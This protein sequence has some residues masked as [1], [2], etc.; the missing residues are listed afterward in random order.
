MSLKTKFIFKRGSKFFAGYVIF[1]GPVISHSGIPY[2]RLEINWNIT[3]SLQWYLVACTSTRSAHVV[4]SEVSLLGLNSGKS[5]LSP[6]FTRNS[7]CR[8]FINLSLTFKIFINFL[9]HF[10]D[11]DELELN[12]ELKLLKLEDYLTLRRRLHF[13]PHFFPTQLLFKFTIFIIIRHIFR[14]F[15]FFYAL[16]F[17]WASYRTNIY[18]IA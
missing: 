18:K 5:N 7:G 16:G 1:C 6:S 3:S 10:N 12:D 8:V 9:V 4:G 2:N 11:R 15:A 14:F 17:F 13:S